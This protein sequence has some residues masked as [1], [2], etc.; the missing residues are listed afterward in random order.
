MYIDSTRRVR[1]A[2]VEVTI[3]G[4]AKSKERGVHLGALLARI[5]SGIGMSILVLTSMVLRD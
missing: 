1:G 2:I 3:E 4:A 5:Q